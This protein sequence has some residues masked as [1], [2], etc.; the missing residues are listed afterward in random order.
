VRAEGDPL[1]RGSAY[2]DDDGDV[3]VTWSDGQASYFGP[4]DNF[5]PSRGAADIRAPGVLTLVASGLADCD[6]SEIAETSRLDLRRAASPSGSWRAGRLRLA[7]RLALQRGR[8]QAARFRRERRWAPAGL[9]LLPELLPGDLL[10]LQPLDGWEPYN[11]GPPPWAL[12]V[13]APGRVR[14]I[15]SPADVEIC[16]DAA[17]YASSF[18]EASDPLLGC[19]PVREVKPRLRGLGPRDFTAAQ[20]PHTLVRLRASLPPKGPA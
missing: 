4:E 17:G 9:A 20:W 19:H 16:A 14:W 5:G 6:C 18:W 12:Y 10:L 1:P 13:G 7:G 15:W 11:V 8:D 2:L 3:L